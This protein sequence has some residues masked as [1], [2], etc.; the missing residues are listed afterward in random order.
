M[1]SIISWITQYAHNAHWY[2]FVAILFAGF[3][4]PISADVMVIL[5]A[6]LAA[7]L[8]P[9]LTIHLW[10]SIF[11]GCTFSAWIA[12]SV[13]RLCGP[14]LSRR[15][16]FTRL[17]PPRRLEKVK[18]FYEKHGFL[19]LLIGRFI[20]FGVRNCIFMSAGMSKMSFPKFA[21][22]DF[23]ACGIW[24]STAFYIFYTLGQNYERL[25]SYLKTFNL[26]IFSLFVVTAIGFIWYKKKKAKPVAD[27]L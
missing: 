16:W 17:L 8:V 15:K 24:S 20:P 5:A 6:V 25:S 21:L 26:I 22:R 10:L 1:D 19:T 2:I 11:L 27:E 13:G 3:N 14:Y 7:T 9:E 12:Y 4:I 18:N 23:I